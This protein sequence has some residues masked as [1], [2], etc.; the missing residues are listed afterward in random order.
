M[1][2]FD[3]ECPF[4]SSVI[5]NT[6]M[7]ATNS[8]LSKFNVTLIPKSP[9]VGSE[10]DLSDT[11]MDHCLLSLQRNESD[12]ILMPYS[13][14]L[15]VENVTIGPVSDQTKI[16]MITAYKLKS[17]DTRPAILGTFDTFGMDSICLILFC[18]I[19]MYA[20]IALTYVLERERETPDYTIKGRK[21]DDSFTP[22]FIFNYF[23]N[24]IPCFPGNMT[25]MKFILF[26]CLMTFSYFVTFFYCSMIKTDM[27]TVKT[28]HVIAS[29][30]DILDDPQA[31]PFIFHVMDEYRTFKYA[32]RESVKGKILQRIVKQ[33]ID[34]H[35]LEPSKATKI[36]VKVDVSVILTKGVMIAFNDALYAGKYMG[37]TR[38]KETNW[39]LLI[40]FDPS[41]HP[42][43]SAHV[44]NQLTPHDIFLRSHSFIRRLFEANLRPKY[45][46]M[47]GKA[48]AETFVDQIPGLSKDLSEVDLY[49][50]ERVLLPESVLIKADIL[51]Y[52]WLFI[53]LLGLYFLAFIVLLIEKCTFKKQEKKPLFVASKPATLKKLS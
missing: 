38:V 50:S 52:K 22:E 15:V 37:L 17:D 23:V 24:Q 19:I 6:F 46:D 49:V 31:E 47:L 35:I 30:Q 16:G 26:C 13:M 51:Y 1:C 8:L 2:L 14:P 40:S 43:I 20:L 39:R 36:A 5:Q 28:P 12:I 7:G 42:V 10:M 4:P 29:Y 27:V 3:E 33:G 18:T 34:T 41:E 25:V 32:P 21:V 9:D 45:Y 44:L 53:S 48:V 11:K